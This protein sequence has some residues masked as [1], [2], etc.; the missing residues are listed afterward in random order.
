MVNLDSVVIYDTQHPAPLAIATDLHHSQLTDVAWGFDTSTQRSSLVV[1]SRDGYVSIMDF[2]DELGEVYMEAK[3][4]CVVPVVPVVVDEVGSRK[5]PES[6]PPLKRVQPT[7]LQPRRVGLES[8]EEESTS[9]SVSVPTPK[10]TIPVSSTTPKST[11]SSIPTSTPSNSDQVQPRRVPL[12][13][14]VQP[15]RVALEGVVDTPRRVVLEGVVEPKRVQLEEVGDQ[16]RRVP[17]VEVVKRVQPTLI[18]EGV[19]RVQPTLIEE[20]P[21]K[22]KM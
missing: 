21:K 20:D 16:P 8:V 18:K 2:G 19:K 14:V 13:A 10:S 7:L 11:T 1:T 6:S 15:R 4:I 3:D 9:V 22:M 17:L 5:K 12:E